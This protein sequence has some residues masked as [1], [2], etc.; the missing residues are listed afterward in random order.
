M[1]TQAKD[2][3][4]HKVFTD[5]FYLFVKDNNN[6]KHEFIEQKLGFFVLK[7]HFCF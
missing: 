6:K 1:F 5:F 4:L 3:Q 2:S 7:L